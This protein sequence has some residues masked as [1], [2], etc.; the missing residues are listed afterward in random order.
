MLATEENITRRYDF[1]DS[2]KAL[3]AI[4]DT[5]TGEIVNRIR[6]KKEGGFDMWRAPAIFLEVGHWVEFSKIE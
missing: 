4:W 2:V 1:S 3:P 6:P 5:L